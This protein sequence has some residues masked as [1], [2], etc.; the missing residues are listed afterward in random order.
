VKNRIQF[1]PELTAALLCAAGWYAFWMFAFRP[2]PLSALITAS[3]PEVTRLA[4]D[5]NPLR[6]LKAPTL[7]ALPS[8]EG[9]SGGFLPDRV[10]LRLTLEKPSN[11]VRY[12]SHE[13]TAAPAINQTTPTVQ[14]LPVQNSLPAPGAAA[15]ETVRQG[16]GTQLF[17]SPELNL[18]SDSVPQLSSAL[19]GRTGTIRINLVVRPDG[20]VE[21]ALFETPVTN[22]ALLSA[23][24]QLRFKP[25]EAR[26][27]GWV[28]IRS[29][30]EGK[31]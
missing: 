9:F 29:A 18:R 16:A 23:V 11:P 20:T 8:D 27:Q 12:L 7:F 14:T 10:D 1:T 21:Q 5:D 19:P 31:E 25:S 26:T 22:A 17:L 6:K 15:T 2:A 3:R 30:Q 13:S 28:D 4:E 24:R